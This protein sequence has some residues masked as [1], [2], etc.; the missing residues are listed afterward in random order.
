MPVFLKGV[1]PWF[2]YIVETRA[3][4]L[5]VDCS[6]IG[7]DLAIRTRMEKKLIQCP[8][9]VETLI[10]IFSIIFFNQIKKVGN[11]LGNPN[12]KLFFGLSLK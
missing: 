3:R 12:S 9:L 2:L 11:T 4:Q 10:S 7:L 6:G 8:P 5:I 1:L